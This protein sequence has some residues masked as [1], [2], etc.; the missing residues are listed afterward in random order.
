VRHVRSLTVLAAAL[1][2][3]LLP[4]ATAQA[5]PPTSGTYLA[6]GDSVAVGTGATDPATQ[7]YVGLLHADLRA[8]CGKDRAGH[9]HKSGQKAKARAHGK[10][11]SCRIELVNLAQDGATTA[12]LVADQLPAALRLISERNGNGTPADDVRLITITIGANDFLGTFRTACSTGDA[13]TCDSA[14][15]EQLSRSRADVRHLL[16]V[17]REAAGPDTLIAVTTLYNALRNPGCALHDQQ[18]LGGTVLEGGLLETAGPLKRGLN[19]DF[20]YEAFLNDAV[21]VE[22]ATLVDPVT[23]TQPDCVNPDAAGHADLARAFAAAVG[24]PFPSRRH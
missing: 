6:L 24:D 19:F 22:A 1:P 14:L 7:G 4:T 10:D 13:R 15:I 21:V 16:G 18:R 2:L 11:T 3:A 5:A 8:D 17:L 23:E 9:P 20:R 12:S